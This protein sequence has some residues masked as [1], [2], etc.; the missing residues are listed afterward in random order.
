MDT[1][2]VKSKQDVIRF[3]QELI[4]DFIENKDTWEN[5]ELSDYLESLQA[6]LEDADDAA[7]DG[8]KWKLLCSALETPKFYE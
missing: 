4:I 5:I 1:D 6:W 2:Q 3:I 7:S 8:N